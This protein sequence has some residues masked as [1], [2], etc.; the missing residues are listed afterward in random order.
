[1][2]AAVGGLILTCIIIF[3]IVVLILQRVHD[4]KS[5]PSNKYFG[6]LKILIM[7]LQIVS[8]LPY[9]IDSVQW[10]EN[11]KLLAMNLSFVNFEF[12]K[13]MDFSSCS[14]S[15]HPLNRF[16][17]HVSFF[18]LVIFVV[19]TAYAT[20]ICIYS[21]SNKVNKMKKIRAVA[22]RRQGWGSRRHWMDMWAKRGLRDLR[23]CKIPHSDMVRPKRPETSFMT[24]FN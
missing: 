18:L 12:M 5:P 3:T 10:P 21:F 17:L 11:F 15:L 2:G 6:Q 19:I 13:L 8:A 24:V 7:F 9:S 14:L 1:M 22:V 23:V 16:A 4:S 20:S